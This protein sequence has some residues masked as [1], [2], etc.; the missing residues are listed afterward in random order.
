MSLRG[1]RLRAFVS[2]KGS[3]LLLTALVL[4]LAVA[5]GQEV[6]RRVDINQRDESL[7]EQIASLERRNE[8]LQTL[9][10]LLQTSSFQ[11]REARQ[12]L[13]LQRP[14]ETAVIVPEQSSGR[15]GVPAIRTEEQAAPQPNPVKWWR[16]FFS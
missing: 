5:V 12:R 6:A 13:N 14:G 1:S 11:E 3:V 9:V 10:D 2:S 7:Q 16:Y 4:A 15:V 8:D